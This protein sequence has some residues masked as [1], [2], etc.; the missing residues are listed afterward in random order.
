MPYFTGPCVMSLVDLSSLGG[1]GTGGSSWN[2][3]VGTLAGRDAFNGEAAGFRVLVA[4]NGNGQA[5]IYQKTATGW[6]V[7]VPFTGA[8][9]NDGQPNTLA[10]G[11]VTEG[12]Q[13]HV[14]ITGTSPNQIVNFVLRRGEKGVMGDA[15]PE[16]FAAKAAAEAAAVKTGLDKNA[17]A[18]DR[19]ATGSDKAAASVTTATTQA[20]IATTKAGE[21]AGSATAT[22]ADRAAVATDKS[23]VAADKATTVT[24]KDKLG[25]MPLK[26]R[27]LRLGNIVLITGRKSLKR[28][29]V[30]GFYR[31]MVKLDLRSR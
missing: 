14:S 6:S 29:R 5:V 30:V 24:A 12:E 25:R 31:L 10:V 18:A 20:G 2:A 21:A 19:V 22:A 13:A 8:K 17:T 11:S 15:T 4:N 26:V 16:A 1:G 23:T 9:G 7:P 27:W 28:L 3:L